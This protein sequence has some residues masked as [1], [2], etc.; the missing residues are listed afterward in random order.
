MLKTLS[1]AAALAL[2]SFAP[3]MALPSVPALPGHDAVIPVRDGCGPGGFR[4]GYGYCR[5]IYRPR[6][7]PPGYHLGRNG[8]RCWPNY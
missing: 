3:A 2:G 8:D 7:C 4:D 1:L 6:A 5:P